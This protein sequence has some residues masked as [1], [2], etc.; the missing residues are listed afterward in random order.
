MNTLQRVASLRPHSCCVMV[1]DRGVMSPVIRELVMAIPSKIRDNLK[2]GSLPNIRR[3]IHRLC[4]AFVFL[5][6]Y[7]QFP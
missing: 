1:G 4:S 2:S 6:S 5:G 7:W 3:G